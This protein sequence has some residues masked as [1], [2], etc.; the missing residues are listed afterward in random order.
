M[1]AS[2]TPD[3]YRPALLC[4]PR[5]LRYENIAGCLT[6]I[7]ASSNRPMNADKTSLGRVALITGSGKRRVG[8]HVADALG[9]RG[10]SLAIHYRTSAAEA[11][12]TVSEF[13]QRGVEAIAIAADLADEGQV[14]HLVSETRQRLGRIDVLVNTAAVWKSRRLEEVTAAD[15]RG[16]FE[17]NTLGTFLCCQHAGLAMAQQQEGGSIITFGDWATTRPYTNY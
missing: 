1:L 5:C 14:R 6:S 9:H 2:R 4:R 15:V 10:Y 17:A 7:T 16:F 11:Q 3:S 12:Q 8:W 13:R